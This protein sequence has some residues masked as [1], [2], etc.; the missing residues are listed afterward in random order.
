MPSPPFPASAKSGWG[1]AVGVI[2]IYLILLLA[3][4]HDGF[5]TLDNGLKYLTIKNQVSHPFRSFDIPITHQEIDPWNEATPLIPP[6]VHTQDHKIIPVFPPAFI[7]LCSLAWKLAGQWIL[8]VIPWLAAIGVILIC[9]R[10]PSA[11]PPCG[12]RGEQKGGRYSDLSDE[13]GLPPRISRGE[14]KGAHPSSITALILIALA[15]PLAFYALTLW[16]HTAAML[17]ITAG[18]ALS[19]R[20]NPRSGLWR[21]ILA[22][23]LL[24]VGGMFRLECWVVAVSWIIASIPLRNDLVNQVPE[25]A[26]L[27]PPFHSRDLSALEESGKPVLRWTALTIGLLTAATVWL[28]TN[29]WWTGSFLPL[30][31]SENWRMY[32]A[33]SGHSGFLGWII[34]RWDALTILLFS[35]HPQSTVNL[36]LN[37][38]M[39]LGIVLAVMPMK[40]RLSPDSRLR[41]NDIWKTIGLVLILGA[42]L[43]FLILE[44]HLDHPIAATAFTGGLLW[45]CPWVI[46]AIPQMKQPP[47]IRRLSI[48][49]LLSIVLIIAMTPI[50]RGIHFGPR[51][52]L[53]VMPLLAIVLSQTA[54]SAAPQKYSQ[55]AVWVLVG[56]TV[57]HQGRGISLL[58]KQK[59]WNAE[60]ASKLSAVEERIVLT[61]LWWV[62]GDMGLTWDTH[63]FFLVSRPEVFEDILFHMKTNGVN[64]FVFCSEAPATVAKLDAPITVE[65]RL[66]WESSERPPTVVELVG[67][68]EDSSKWAALATKVGLRQYAPETLD[69][70]LIPFEAAV[71]W[72]P[73]NPDAWYQLGV[74]K[75][76]LWDEEGA[77]KAFET[78]VSID[79]THQP[80]LKALRHWR[81]VRG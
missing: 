15:S 34:A 6:F 37:V 45:T 31:F 67:L 47:E 27:D 48:A 80:S 24:G 9:W 32:G 3:T 4:S 23:V 36:L 78:A 12:S 8:S 54:F 7:V 53:G 73:R 46:L 14:Q 60:L 62:P 69:R 58:E 49:I 21:W 52:L 38:A 18:V 68:S 43:T 75:S 64:H 74:L 55:I 65:N 17:C 39:I 10:F 41:G 25:G 26:S 79:S 44:W 20:R 28:F 61:D 22:G 76:E 56:L 13:S 33:S 35:A 81:N 63:S 51:L 59:S 11:I 29:F 19:F 5:W 70:A 30:Q 1:L 42:Y 2:A 77:R 66:T 57:I 40:H 16:E 72:S 71:S 50:S